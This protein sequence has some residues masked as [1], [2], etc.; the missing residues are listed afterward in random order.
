MMQRRNLLKT[1]ALAG[2]AS[3]VPSLPAWAGVNDPDKNKTIRLHNPNNNEKLKATFWRGD[4]FDAGALSEI[5]H[6]MRD[7]RENETVDFDPYLVLMLHDVCEQ[8][9]YTGDVIV[10][11]GYRTRK[12]NNWLLRDSRYNAAPNSL[13]LEGRAVDFTLPRQPLREVRNAARGLQVGGLGYYPRQSFIHADTG[14]KRYWN[15]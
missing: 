2:V 1:L 8:C 12:T 11:S 10:L 14:R 9:H 15:S 4:W 3:A 6:F 5:S 7:W 13:H